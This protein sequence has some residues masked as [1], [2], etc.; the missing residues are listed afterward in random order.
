MLGTAGKHE[1]QGQQPGHDQRLLQIQR[2]VHRRG[3]PHRLL[4][5][6]APDDPAQRQQGYQ[7]QCHHARQQRHDQSTVDHC[8]LDQQTYRHGATGQGNPGAKQCTAAAIYTGH[9]R[10]GQGQCGTGSQAAEQRGQHQTDPIPQQPDREIAGEADAG[11]ENDQPAD[12]LGIDAVPG[13]HGLIGQQWQHHQHYHQQLQGSI[14][15]QPRQIAQQRVKTLL[16]A[17][18]HGG[19]HGRGGRLQI[20]AMYCQGPQQE[21]QQGCHFGGRTEITGCPAGVDVAGDKQSGNAGQGRRQHP[22]AAEDTQLGHY[23]AGQSQQTEGADT[24]HRLVI[25]LFVAG[26]VQILRLPAPFE[27][28]D[29]PDRHSDQQARQLDVITQSIHSL[30][31]SFSRPA[32]RPV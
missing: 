14:E 19:D 3:V 15:L 13:A 27:A 21:G 8:H 9:P 20:Q 1:D 31:A 23:P 6:V 16:G 29:Q 18:Q 30:S 2:V 10:E 17:E 7:R 28:D 26:A 25:Y 24:G 11:N 32:H 4:A 12:D 5:A 22:V